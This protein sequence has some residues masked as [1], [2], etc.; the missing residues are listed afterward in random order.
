M[1]ISILMKN[2]FLQGLHIK[3]SALLRVK[4]TKKQCLTPITKGYK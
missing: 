1:I 2:S 3:I 4:S